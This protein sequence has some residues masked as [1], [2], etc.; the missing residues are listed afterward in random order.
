MEINMENGKLIVIAIGGNAL[1]EDNSKTSVSDQYEAARKTASFIVKL[2]KEGLKVVVVHGNGPQVGHALLRSEMA[3]ELLES[4]PLDTCVANTQGTIGYQLQMAIR[5]EA[6][7]IDLDLEVATVVTQ[8]EVDPTDTA[9]DNPTKPIGLFMDQQE[10]QS[11]KEKEGWSVVEDSG[12]GYRRVV[13]SPK[14]IKIVE[15]KT[16]KSLV[17]S[18]IVVI[19]AGGGGIPVVNNNHLIVGNES[20]ID[21]DSAAALLAKELK[22]DYFVVSTAVDNVYLSYGKADQKELGTITIKEAAKFV[23]Q[24]HF[25]VGSMLPKVLSAIDFVETTKGVALITSN[26]NL[27][28][29]IYH[30][31]GTKIIL[32]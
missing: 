28:D 21:K 1:I 19:A 12:R 20:V 14:P 30:N 4:E 15:L 26:E 10:A 11:R 13:A 16:I 18:N 9:F 23:E 31:K 8:V 6:T 27:Y 7:K 3:K 24:G 29:A 17:E 25:A 5:N 2:I 22:A 32:K